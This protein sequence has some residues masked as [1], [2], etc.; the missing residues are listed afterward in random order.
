MADWKREF[1]AAAAQGEIDS[2]LEIVSKSGKGHEDM[3]NMGGSTGQEKSDGSMTT[4]PM[5]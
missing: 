2:M 5:I 4:A 3:G 1:A